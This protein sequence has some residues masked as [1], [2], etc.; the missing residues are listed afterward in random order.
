MASDQTPQNYK[1]LSVQGELGTGVFLQ[2]GASRETMVTFEQNLSYDLCEQRGEAFAAFK[3]VPLSVTSYAG[4]VD[5][6]CRLVGEPCSNT[7]DADGCLCNPASK[8]C[9]DASG[10]SQLPPKG[11]LTSGNTGNECAVAEASGS[12]SRR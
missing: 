9:A 1:D 3:W 11:N 8:Q 7:C 4:V 2:T 6:R 12:H 5:S 10:N